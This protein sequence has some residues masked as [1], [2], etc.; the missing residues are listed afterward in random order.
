MALI[1]AT[2]RN[3]ARGKTHFDVHEIPTVPRS[4]GLLPHYSRSMKQKPGRGSLR[5]VH[6]NMLL[7]GLTLWSTRGP[8]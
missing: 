8:S 1:P 2:T 3:G 5:I 7:R 4:R 6:D